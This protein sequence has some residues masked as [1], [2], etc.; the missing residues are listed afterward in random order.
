M[1][2]IDGSE[3]AKRIDAFCAMNGISK[4][5]EEIKSI[6]GALDEITGQT[7]LLSLN[8]PLSWKSYTNRK[9]RFLET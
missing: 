1:L 6:L 3:L 5:S 2:N 8:E 7:A 4:T 9:G